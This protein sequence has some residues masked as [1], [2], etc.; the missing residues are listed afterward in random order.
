MTERLNRG[1]SLHLSNDL[2]NAEILYKNIILDDGA[3]YEAIRLLG[4]LMIQTSRLGAGIAMLQKAL[5]LKPD[6]PVVLDNL[7]VAFKAQH[8]YDDA[9]ASFDKA[10]EIDPAFA[11]AQNNRAITLRES[12]KFEE[13]LEGY[14]K[15]LAIAPGHIGVLNDHGLTLKDLD[16][17]EEAL[18]SFD[19][20]L[21]AYPNDEKTLVNRG[22]T[23]K[24]LGRH[25][26]AIDCFERALA[27]APHYADAIHNR[28]NALLE[29]RKPEDALADYDRALA[30]VP[31]NIEFL[32][33]KANA[34]LLLAD[35]AQGW[36]LYESR[37]ERLAFRDFFARR[38]F[39]QPVCG[40]RHSL[41]GKTL[42]LWWEQG[43][44]DTLQFCRYAKIAEAEGARVILSAQNRLHKLLSSLSPTIELIDEAGSPAKF[45]CHASLMSMPLAFSV[46]LGSM[47]DQ[48]PYLRADADR[49]RKWREGIGG[50]GF[51]IGVAWNSSAANKRGLSRSFKLLALESLART[52]G[53]RL[54]SLQKHDGLDQLRDLPVGFRVE[55]LGEDFDSGDDAFIDTAAVLE[56]LDL[57]ITCDTS[58]AHLA[59]ALGRPTWLAL[60]YAPEW[61]WMLDRTN[62]PWYPTLR[63]FRQKNPGDWA[64]VFTEMELRLREIVAGLN[65]ARESAAWSMPPGAGGAKSLGA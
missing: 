33:S 62:S 48:A 46:D 38:S 1:I 20:A 47:P 8:R 49:V 53:V 43:F 60:K 2:E 63:L 54:I 42:F 21:A 36:K 12:K 65:P 28:G 57:V 14:D 18:A 34:A 17:H 37:K 7:G 3:N 15:V 10:L 32:F 23:L 16:R 5:R 11:A 44:G 35:F 45:D 24:E 64:G 22:V 61:R 6:H 41:L 59:G 55:T 27:V 56:N 39:P 26:E 13:A 50:H 30:L 25:G 52:P 31:A 58:I 4:V 9:I 29:L 40:P 19:K 51:K